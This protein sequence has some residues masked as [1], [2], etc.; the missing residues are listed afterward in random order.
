LAGNDDQP[1]NR[2][3]SREAKLFREMAQWQERFFKILWRRV[4]M[5]ERIVLGIPHNTG[6]R[7][8]ERME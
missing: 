3:H 5:V 6:G 1:T 8:R 2:F 7:I 4:L